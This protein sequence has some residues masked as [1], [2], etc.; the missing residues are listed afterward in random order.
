MRRTVANPGAGVF[1][2]CRPNPVALGHKKK[3][4]V[5]Y[6]FFCRGDW[7]RTSDLQLPKNERANV[8]G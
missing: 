6:L 5:Q 3:R 7:I 4:Y 2:I 8:I 1:C